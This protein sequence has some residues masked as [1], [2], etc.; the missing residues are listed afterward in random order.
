MINSSGTLVELVNIC[1]QPEEG[2]QL[3]P[4]A[5]QVLFE[6]D[7]VATWHTHPGETSTL[8]TGDYGSFQA[9]PHLRHYVVG[10]DGVSCYKVDEDG[11]VVICE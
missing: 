1:D 5:V 10:K 2:F 4:D 11:A 7:T 3:S 6:D 9:Y 8:S